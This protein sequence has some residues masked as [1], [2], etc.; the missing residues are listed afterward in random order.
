MAS[1]GVTAACSGASSQG[2]RVSA[3]SASTRPNGDSVH[4]GWPSLPAA[5]RTSPRV[6][7]AAAPTSTG[8]WPPTAA[9]AQLACRNSSEVRTRSCALV[10]IRSG[11]QS[12]T[13]VPAG[14]A[15]S[16][17]S[18]ESGPTSTGASDSI[19][20]T[21]M[22]S[23]SLSRISASS[24]CCSA[25]AA[26]RSRT[27]GVSSNSRQGGA[28]SSGTCSMVRWSATAKVRISSTSSPQNSTRDGCSSVGG[29]TSRMPP[30]TANSPR[31]VTRSTRAYAMSISRRATSSRSASSPAASCTG[32]RSPSPF[33]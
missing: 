1:S 11:S 3:V 17:S 29:K 6:R 2:C 23:A 19:P 28:Q 32:S 16:S 18:S 30:R 9:A 20:S 13:W 12:S 15:S 25:S 10:R 4:H 8:A 33:S 14:M 24:G 27:A 26:A 5:A 7:N 21:G 31:L 22:P